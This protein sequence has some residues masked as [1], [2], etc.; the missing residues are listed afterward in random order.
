MQNDSDHS[1]FTYL[2]NFSVLGHLV[3]TAK[4]VLE[5]QCF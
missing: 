3:I 4:E 2:I 5:M 1:T